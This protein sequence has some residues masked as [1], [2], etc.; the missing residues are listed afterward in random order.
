MGQGSINRKSLTE[1]IA[2]DMASQISQGILEP[3]SELPSEQDLSSSYEVSR[4]VIREALKR[5]DA[6]GYLVIANGRRARVKEPGVD[7]LNLFLDRVLSQD[8]D[9]WRE[10]V[11]VREALESVAAR[12]AAMRAT[13]EEKAELKALTQTMRESLEAPHAFS[14]A[15]VLFHLTLA[16][17]SGNRLLNYLV[18]ATR[19]ALISIMRGLRKT[20]PEDYL[21]TVQEAH[22]AIVAAIEARN[23][24][25][26]EKA[27]KRHFQ[28]VREQLDMQ[29]VE[30]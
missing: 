2:E 25:A 29:E 4:P 9:S 7:L 3:G 23:P 13:E 15:D 11:A 17:V 6:R 28:T 5:L 19:S 24:E 10:L 16:R 20:V 26:A 27:M 1:Q 30:K 8:V 22:E 21:P 12:E 18:E 14:E